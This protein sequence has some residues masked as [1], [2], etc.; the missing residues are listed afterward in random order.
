LPPAVYDVDVTVRAPCGL[1]NISNPLYGYRFKRPAVESTFG[2]FLA[3]HPETIRCLADGTMLS[4][5]TLSNEQMNYV[6]EDLTS[7]V[8]GYSCLAAGSLYGSLDAS[9]VW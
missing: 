1:V 5:I 8:V 6:A 7:E 9:S 3:T 2:G 4:N